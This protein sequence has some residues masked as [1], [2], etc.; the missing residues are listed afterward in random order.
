ME[1]LLY[2]SRTLER[3]EFNESVSIVVAVAR[4]ELMAQ[5]DTALDGMFTGD[6]LASAAPFLC[7]LLLCSFL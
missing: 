3:G 2:N 7:V 5:P 6:W 1:S 4:G